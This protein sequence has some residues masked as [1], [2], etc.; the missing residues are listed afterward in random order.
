MCLSLSKVTPARAE[1]VRA[2]VH[3]REEGMLLY[4]NCEKEFPFEPPYPGPSA[5]R[6][7]RAGGRHVRTQ[8]EKR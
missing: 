6:G 2:Y 3:R 4:V 1:P 5:C 8:F 7:G